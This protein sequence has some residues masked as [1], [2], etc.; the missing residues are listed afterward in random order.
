MNSIG[1]GDKIP[2]LTLEGTIQNTD[3]YRVRGVRGVKLRKKFKNEPVGQG[4]SKEGKA[5]R[6][7]RRQLLKPKWRRLDG[8]VAGVV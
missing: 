6:V 4:A 3:V 2:K 8:A 5:E 1:P 7:L